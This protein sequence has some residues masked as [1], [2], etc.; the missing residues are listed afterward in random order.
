MT[1]QS[2]KINYQNLQLLQIKTN[3]PQIQLLFLPFYSV[4]CHYQTEY[5]I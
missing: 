2:L 3:L 1:Q 5:A 4:H